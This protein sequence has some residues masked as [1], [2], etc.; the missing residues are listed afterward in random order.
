[1][2]IQNTPITYACSSEHAFRLQVEGHLAQGVP[3]PPRAH[4]VFCPS[5]T[6][7]IPIINLSS[8]INY[9]NQLCIAKAKTPGV[10]R[11]A[12]GAGMSLGDPDL[13]YYKQHTVLSFT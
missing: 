6:Q 2:I 11:G 4:F 13:T 8:S 1:M 3:T 7:L 10:G 12:G 9:L 5:I